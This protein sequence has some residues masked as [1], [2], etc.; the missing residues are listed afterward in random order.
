MAMTAVRNGSCSV[1]IGAELGLLVEE[2]DD[3]DDA[4]E[5]AWALVPVPEAVEEAESYH[6]SAEQVQRKSAG[7]TYCRILKL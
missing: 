3:D 1:T 5:P 2:V 6:K 4:V 7:D